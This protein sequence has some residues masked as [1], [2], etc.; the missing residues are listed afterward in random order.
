MMI[1]FFNYSV[2]GNAR[3]FAYFVA[4]IIE[5]RYPVDLDIAL[6]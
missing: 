5:S 6:Y 4:T 1:R 2:A 3:Y